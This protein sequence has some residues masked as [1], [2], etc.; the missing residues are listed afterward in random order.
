[1]AIQYLTTE[2][3]VNAI[4]VAKHV[5]QRGQNDWVVYTGN[6][7]P[8]SLPAA[9][10]N[11]D[12]NKEYAPLL[13]QQEERKA[14]GGEIGVGDVGVV[15][16]RFDDYQDSMRDVV[17]PL[18]Q[19]R[20]IPASHALLSEFQALSYG[21]GVS[22]ADIKTMVANG[23]EIWSHGKVHKDYLGPDGL[24]EEIVTSKEL[25]EAQG[26]KVQGFSLPGVTSLYSAAIRGNATPYNGLNNISLYNS[27]EGNLLMR[28]YA[29]SEAY[30]G[31][32][33]RSIPNGI[34]HGTDH[35][36]VDQKT[37]VE[38]KSLVD[39]AIAYKMALRF[40][41]HPGNL[42]R[43]GG[44]LTVADFT[45]LLDYCVTAWDAGTLEIVT[46]SALA[47]LSKSAYRTDLLRAGNLA[48][49]S[50]AAPLG[51]LNIDDGVANTVY[52]TG[53]PSNG[54]Y[55][56][57]ATT[58]PTQRPA[59]LANRKIGGEVFL[60][61]GWIKSLGASTTIATITITDYP[62]TSALSITKT[63]A[64]VGNAT[65]QRVRIPFSIPVGADSISI[66]PGRS[67]GDASGWANMSV[68]KI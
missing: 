64:G 35:V 4:Y 16:F 7:I 13:L 5:Y 26:I 28:T 11:L 8:A 19:S 33:F 52:Q 23:I 38:L 63:Y 6:D 42:D 43:S 24:R 14:K 50:L 25:I 17:F 20:G 32:A 1:M 27:A 57:V 51:W 9:D 22:W 66:A 39:E 54:P 2:A 44:Y 21:S 62:A 53:G 31:G 47:F 67:S 59:R 48:G 15:A 10:S 49:V 68:K 60:F 12:A 37:L 46:P 40:M 34:Y 30:C 58:G 45:S 56:S 65:W 36:T 3:A 29:Q 41:C 55:L 61:E 18:L